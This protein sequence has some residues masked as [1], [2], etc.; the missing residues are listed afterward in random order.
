[1]KSGSFWSLFPCI[2]TFITNYRYLKAMVPVAWSLWFWELA[3]PLNTQTFVYIR[4]AV[5]INETKWGKKTQNTNLC[6]SVYFTIMGD[7]SYITN[8]PGNP[9]SPIKPT[10]LECFVTENWFVKTVWKEIT[11]VVLSLASIAFWLRSSLTIICTVYHLAWP[12]GYKTFFM[13]NSAEHE[14]FSANKYENANNSWH[15]HIY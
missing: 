13:L 4:T 10:T 8:T 15:F 7:N 11:Y 12:W 14:I 2:S 6:F 3:V 1:M 9:V 5:H